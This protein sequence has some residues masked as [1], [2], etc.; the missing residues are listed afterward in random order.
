M[1]G[2]Y[3][4]DADPLSPFPP[5]SEALDEHEGLLAV[6]AD[7][8]PS[9]IFNAYRSG[10]FPW[11][12]EGEPIAW[13]SPPVRMILP[14]SENPLGRRFRKSLVDRN[15]YLTADRDFNEVMRHCAEVV[16]PGQNGT[17]INADMRD[18]YRTLHAEGISHSVEVRRS[19]DGSLVGGL[20]GLFV[21]GMF[22]GDSM[23]SLESGASKVAF[24]GL[25]QFLR[26]NGVEWIDGQLPNPYLRS[27]GGVECSRDEFI[28]YLHGS[29][30]S[31]LGHVPWVDFFGEVPVADFR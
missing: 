1:T 5:L 19:E 16:R 14:T 18:A 20:Y 7:L 28:R 3:F 10:I 29:G 31:E 25:C 21:R 17:W 30:E 8:H 26:E 22:C 27:L 12:N 6:T 9:R 11:Y 15:W 23:F 4:L 13:Y 2:P 24:A